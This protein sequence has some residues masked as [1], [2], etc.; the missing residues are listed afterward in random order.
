[1]SD[2]GPP[3]PPPARGGLADT[4]V[5]PGPLVAT[6]CRYAG[7]NQPVAAGTLER[8]H[9]VTGPALASLVT[10]LDSPSLQ[11]IPD[12]AVYSCPMDQGSTDLLAFAY[13]TGPAVTV[14]VAILGCR[15]MTNGART[16]GGA[17]LG[18]R[19]AA[20]VGTDRLP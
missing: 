12:S 18:P 14:S 2:P 11:V 13:P 6:V 3:N 10:A 7:R 19:L 15:F 9:V 17:E 1:V 4:L 8:T 5:P 20:W 16:V